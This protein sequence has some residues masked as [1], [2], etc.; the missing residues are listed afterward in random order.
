MNKTEL[1]NIIQKEAEKEGLISSNDNLTKEAL[2]IMFNKQVVPVKLN[3]IT[4]YVL[5]FIMKVGTE[6]QDDKR[7]IPSSK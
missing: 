3:N 7:S 4:A 2:R 5:K 1:L 6:D